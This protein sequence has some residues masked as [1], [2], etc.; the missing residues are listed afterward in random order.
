[1]DLLWCGGTSEMAVSRIDAS[2]RAV[3]VNNKSSENESQE[4]CHPLFPGSS[5]LGQ[6]LN[7]LLGMSPGFSDKLVC[8]PCI[9]ETAS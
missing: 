4:K 9:G 1:M 5:C 8:R 6:S 2:G 3:H 7:V